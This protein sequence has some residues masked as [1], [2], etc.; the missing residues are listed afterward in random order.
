MSFCQ[1]HLGETLIS[2]ALA[3]LLSLSILTGTLSGTADQFDFGVFRYQ[4]TTP[5][6]DILIIAIDNQTLNHEGTDFNYYQINR[7]HYAQAI[8]NILSGDPTAIGVD[9]FFHGQSTDPTHDQAL[10]KLFAENPNLITANEYDPT[11]S[12]IIYPASSLLIPYDQQGYIRVASSSENEHNLI[13]SILF[14]PIPTN[15][16]DTFIEPFTVKIFRTLQ[17]GLQS[18][19]LDLTNQTYTIHRSTSS[20][21]IPLQNSSANIN[22]YGPPYSFQMVSFYDVWAGN[23]SPTT[24]HEK[25]V[26]IGS[27]AEDLHDEFF[28][29]VSLGRFMPG[30]EIHA[31][32]L[33][34]LLTG[35]FLTYQTPTSQALTTTCI[36]LLI[37]LIL[38]SFGFGLGTVLTLLVLFG[39]YYT[40]IHLFRSQNLIISSFWPILGGTLTWIGTY[41]Y[42]FLRAEKAKKQIRDAF[43]RYVSPEIVNE[44]I[45][46][47]TK[48]QLG[49]QTREVTILFSD[50]KNFTTHAENLTPAQTMQLINTYLDHMSSLILTRHG[51]IDKYIGD[52]IMALW[53]TPLPHP[54]HPLTACHSALEQI[55]A[56]PTINTKLKKQNLPPLSIRIG[57]HTGPV[58]CGN[59]GTKDRLEYTSLGDSVNLASR[60]EGINKQY[61]THIIISQTTQE[62]VK[63]HFHLREL[64][65]IRVKGKQHPLKIYELICL[66]SQ[67]T[68][69]QIETQTIYEK[70]LSHYRKQQWTEAAHLF[71]QL[72][73]DPP[74]QTMLKRI[75]LFKTEKM[76]DNWDGTQT[77]LTK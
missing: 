47:P 72:A 75:E 54:H 21:E 48:L 9:V 73:T 16:T 70:A 74:S 35:D 27:T 63:D 44:I 28:T 61:G 58:I 57:I 59:I 51:T 20:T 7:S 46:D 6:P 65:L 40:S 1:K 15:S 31:N 60:L 77:F 53:G 13:N 5:S 68:H 12:E 69:T 36:I 52:A 2:L 55:Q 23:I 34:T 38:T 71:Q 62:A 45:K 42:G 19:D 30:V 26:L 66:K 22:F 14:N 41:I 32:F 50:I 24:F 37:L 29:P 64:D 17:R 49:G 10:N 4:D 56:L 39:L 67:A 3:A 8:H 25:I 18:A 76:P 43:S 33:Q 11:T